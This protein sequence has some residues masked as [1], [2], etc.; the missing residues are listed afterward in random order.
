MT[1]GVR[2]D[3]DATRRAFSGLRE[4]QQ[5]IQQ[6]FALPGFD[7]LSMGMSADYAVAIAEGATLIRIGTGIFGPR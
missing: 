4:L 2:A 6:Q 3:N 5:Q 1:I 7:Q